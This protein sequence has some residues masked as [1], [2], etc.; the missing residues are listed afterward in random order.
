MS[1]RNETCV[2]WAV[3][4]SVAFLLLGGKAPAAEPA[5]EIS[6]A[7]QPEADRPAV[8]YRM[9]ALMLVTWAEW[10]KDPKHCDTLAKFIVEKGFNAV[11]V[12]ADRLELCRRNGLYARLGGDIN[13]MLEQAAKLKDD[14]AV[15]CYFISDRRRASSF[16][17]FAQI[18]R[19]YEKADPNHPTMFINRAAWNEFPQFVEQVQPM[20]LDYYHYHWDGRRHPERRFIYLAMFRELGQQHGIPV[21]RC[22]SASVSPA[23][24]RQTI[25]TSLAYGVQGFHFWPPWHFGYKK[26]ENGPV[27]EDGRLVPHVNVPA[28]AEVATELN[29]LGPVLIELRSTAVYHTDPLQPGCGK[30]PENHWV[31]LAGEHLMMGLFEDEKQQYLMV[32]NRDVGQGREA[33]LRFVGEVSAVERMDKSTGR[34]VALTWEDDGERAVTKFMLPPG[35]GELLRV[36]RVEKP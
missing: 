17:V 2:R 3:V 24:L 18:A 11:E 22:V 19:A 36:T 15:F 13:E 34:W 32:V 9:P 8:K 23:Q 20:L 31:Q 14:P 28:L 6:E 26:D 7:D 21:M 1:H 27:L 25:Y 5:R 12:E 35:A 30:A 4:L 29:P 33:M 10:P 16:P